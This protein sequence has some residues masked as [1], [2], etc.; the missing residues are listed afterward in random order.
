M[1]NERHKPQCH[2]YFTSNL[3]YGRIGP[4]L[5]T[6]STHCLNSVRECE[7]FIFWCEIGLNL[8]VLYHSFVLNECLRI[9]LIKIAFTL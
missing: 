1:C 6:D 5:N 8:Y 7:M 2:V 9:R 3:I 4:K